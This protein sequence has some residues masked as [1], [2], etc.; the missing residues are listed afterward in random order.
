[1]LKE[2]LTT[3]EAMNEGQPC[4]LSD[5]Q[6]IS[7]RDWFMSNKWRINFRTNDGSFNDFASVTITDHK[8]K[9]MNSDS[10]KM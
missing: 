3:Y 6:K 2:K 5:D 7:A 8:Y 9:T 1:M 4:T 10:I